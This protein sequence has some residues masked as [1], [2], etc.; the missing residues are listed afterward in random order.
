M[1]V[2]RFPERAGVYNRIWALLCCSVCGNQTQSPV[3]V[4][5]GGHAFC[6]LCRP[7]RRLKCY[8]CQ[9]GTYPQTLNIINKVSDLLAAKMEEI[10]FEKAL[11][12]LFECPVCY[13]VAKNEHEY[14]MCSRGHLVCRFCYLMTAYCP[15]CRE[16]ETVRKNKLVSL[17]IREITT[18]YRCRFAEYG[19]RETCNIFASRRHEDTCIYRH[20]SC[21]VSGCFWKGTIDQIQAHGLDIHR[22]LMATKNR[23]KFSK[24][25][26]QVRFGDDETHPYWLLYDYSEEGVDLVV[27]SHSKHR[28]MSAKVLLGEVGGPS[29]SFS[30]PALQMADDPLTHLLTSDHLEIPSKIISKY[31]NNAELNMDVVLTISESEKEYE[32]ITP[33]NVFTA[34]FVLNF[35]LFTV[36]H[37]GLMKQKSC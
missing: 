3:S 30:Q 26:F 31:S 22:D 19:C 6:R 14:E 34:A 24:G 21:L 11:R 9:K 32:W 27:Q 13:K 20:V 36:K 10:P 16:S 12:D 23:L 29:V 15:L 17:I 5:P 37:W 2:L 1:E 35:F 18:G 8:I 4:C 7:R 28:N 25:S 33:F